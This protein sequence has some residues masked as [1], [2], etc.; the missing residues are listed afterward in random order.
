MDKSWFPEKQII[1]GVGFWEKQMVKP[2]RGDI[3]TGEFI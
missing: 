2:E 1:D 3:Y